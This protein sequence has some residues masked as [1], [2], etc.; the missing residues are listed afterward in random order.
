MRIK[1][2]EFVGAAYTA[3]QYA[4]SG[5]P[6]IAIVGRS[7]SGKSSLINTVCNNRKLA[8]V[9]SEPGKTRSVNFF[10]INREFML[11]DL[12]GYGFAKRGAREKESWGKLVEGY[13]A[14][15]ENLLH[16]LLLCDI[17]HN[18]SD[19]DHTMVNWLRY[20]DIP[21]TLIAT[22]C[23]KIA[24]SKRSGYVNKLVEALGAGS[25]IAFSA[26]DGTG[27]EDVLDKV[28]DILGKSL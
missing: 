5:M 23:D 21:F 16:L 25:G 2:A 8:R 7:N 22:K 18:P 15:S 11:V 13:F 10:A 27:K 24:K 28:S 26:L 19:G 14:A 1:Q 20:Y 12:P 9:S 4:P 6:E 17:R 3:E